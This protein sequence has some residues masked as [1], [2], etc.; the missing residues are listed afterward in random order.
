MTEVRLHLHLELLDDNDVRWW[1]DTPDVDGFYAVGGSLAELRERAS[2]ALTGY[3]DQKVRIAE[4]LADAP[5]TE[6]GDLLV[7]AA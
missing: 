1:A 6:D 3:L 4:V 5:S 7:L 2:I